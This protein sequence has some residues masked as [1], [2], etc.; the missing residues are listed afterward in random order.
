M[1][2]E[3]CDENGV[4]YTETSLGEALAT[5]VAYLNQVGLKN[6]DP[7]TCPLVRELRG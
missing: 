1:V 2:R 4:E 7:F 5:V 6:R 3:F